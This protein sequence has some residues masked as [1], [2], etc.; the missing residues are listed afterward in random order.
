MALER[1]L[2][3]DGLTRLLAFL[4]AEPLIN[5][6]G[7]KSRQRVKDMD[8]FVDFI[9]RMQ[10]PYYEEARIHFRDEEVLNVFSGS[11]EYSP[12]LPDALKDIAS[13]RPQEST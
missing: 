1:F 4:S 10:T 5:S 8:E 2:G 12:Y 3:Q 9:R 7:A 11:N 13:A 6:M